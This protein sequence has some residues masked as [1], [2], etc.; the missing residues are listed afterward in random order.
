MTVGKSPGRRRGPAGHDAGQ[1]GG[2]DARG[3]NT[4]AFL[5]VGLATQEMRP[6][7]S[8]LAAVGADRRF[9]SWLTGVYAGQ[10]TLL[11]VLMGVGVTAVATPA[12]LFSLDIGW[13]L[14]PWL[15]LAAASAGAV[16]AAVVAGCLGGS[17]VATLL[18]TA[19]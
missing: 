5:T 7:L 9:R 16:A 12:L 18:R 13:S 8:A 1:R 2:A 10:V 14:W 6:D 11:G 3:G 17:R 19:Q 15:G 4:L